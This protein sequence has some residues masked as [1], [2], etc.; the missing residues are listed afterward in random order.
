MLIIYGLHLLKERL[1][2]NL[3]FCLFGC[4]FF[5]PGSH[6]GTLSWPRML[7][8]SGLSFLS[9]G[10]MNVCHHTKLES[11]CQPLSTSIS[12]LLSLPCS[13]TQI[14]GHQLFSPRLSTDLK[15]LSRVGIRIMSTVH[16]LFLPLIHGLQRFAWI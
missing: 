2:A 4:F 11:Q 13:T 16:T 12:F 7:R 5:V 9:A 6:C 14:W 3:N 10:V 8:S 15:F 1:L